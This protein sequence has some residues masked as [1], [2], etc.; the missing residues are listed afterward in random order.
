M[1][2]RAPF[3]FAYEFL[4]VSLL[5]QFLAILRSFLAIC[6]LKIA[7]IWKSPRALS[8]F[9]PIYNNVLMH[10][11]TL[12]I[13]L[14]NTNRNILNIHL[15]ILNIILQFVIFLL[16][17]L[18]TPIP[19]KLPIYVPFTLSNLLFNKTPIFPKMF[20]F[21]RF[22]IQANNP[23]SLKQRKYALLYYRLNTTL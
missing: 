23:Y 17:Q 14:Y 16:S 10:V 6:P 9:I 20:N 11:S 13:T 22:T 8:P 1:R 2:S 18:H 15:K 12:F 19:H 7:K 4:T 3:L 21:L 5:L